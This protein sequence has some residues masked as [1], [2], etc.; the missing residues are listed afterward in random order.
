M[1]ETSKE[2]PR[3][4]APRH[5]RVAAFKNVED[6]RTHLSSLD[7]EFGCDDEILRAPESPLAQAC[8]IGD[9]C[10]GNR[11]AIQPMEGW[12]G[13]EDGMPTD[14]VRR[15]WRNFGRSG[16]KLL[17]GGE[18][19]AVCPEGRA[20]PN[21]LMA[22]KST[23]EG[24]R[25][26]FGITI[27]AHH[28][29]YGTTD[30][31]MLGL[32]LTHSGRF[33]RPFSKKRMEPC[34]AYH[35]PILDSKFGLEPD[36]P[37]VTDDYLKDLIELYVEAAGIAWDVG[38][39]FVDIKHCHGY[40]GHELLSA[41]TR[42]GPFGG[43]FENRMRFCRE[44]V[45]GIRT[46]TPQL[47][48]GLRLSA[49][50]KV[51][52]R[53]DPNETQGKQMGIGIPESFK[54]LLPY[55]YGFGLDPNDPVEIDL[56]EPQ[57]FLAALSELGVNLIN[58]TCGSPYYNPHIQRPALFPP[59][60]GYQPPEDPLVGVGRQLALT[61]K[62]KATFPSMV[63]V[64]SGY[65]YLQEFLPLVGQAAVRC[66]DVDFVGLGRFVLSYP[67]LPHD[68]L[69]GDGKLVR[70]SICRTFSDCTTAPR[71]GIVSGCFPLDEF[72]KNSAEFHQLKKIKAS[73][74]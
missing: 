1:A 30:D 21:Q 27:A 34:I 55:Y 62:L 69:Y 31:L 24:I 5:P 28:E 15:R 72:Y 35:H 73:K 45:E 50:D 71:N 20:N 43:S 23:R 18:A 51:P 4:L 11:F 66:E 2:N 41:F 53:P 60:D 63:F 14:Y 39:N 54:E 48:I 17:W 3:A 6:F 68:I 64:G 65:S 37:I 61:K 70:K 57:K 49:I 32:Q 13:T 59:S 19:F 47:Q 10:V 74:S 9:K 26:L 40:L 36:Y 38:F 56:N 29:R 22:C 44:I 46:E 33:C 52:F 7:V 8:Q 25:E 42:P 67:D 12:D 58:L 16:A